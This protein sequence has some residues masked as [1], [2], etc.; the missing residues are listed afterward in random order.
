MQ[1][2]MFDSSR[3]IRNSKM[4]VP[5]IFENIFYMINVWKMI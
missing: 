3:D 4:E 1:L 5:R 2:Y